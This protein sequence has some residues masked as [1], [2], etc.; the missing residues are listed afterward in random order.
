MLLCLE[1]SP[2]MPRDRLARVARDS[3]EVSSR[4][5]RP[6]NHTSHTTDAHKI[7]SEKLGCLGKRRSPEQH[8]PHAPRRPPGRGGC[9]RSPDGGPRRR[10]SLPLKKFTRNR[11]TTGARGPAAPSG[12]PRPPGHFVGPRGPTATPFTHTNN[13]P[14]PTLPAPTFESPHRSPRTSKWNKD[15][16][17]STR[18][19]RRS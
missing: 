10:P 3:V 18:T 1:S 19:S 15:P 6:K 16:S 9:A 14:A 5:A 17:S 12:C 7:V 11:N 8:D 13:L 2:G 4:M